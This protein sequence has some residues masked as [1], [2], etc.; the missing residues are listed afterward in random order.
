MRISWGSATLSPASWSPQG[1]RSSIWRRVGGAWISRGNRTGPPVTRADLAAE[2]LLQAGLPRVA[3][4]VP[5]V[6]EETEPP[7]E[8]VRE[9][10]LVD[11][12]DGTKEFLAGRGEFT[13]QAALLHEGRATLGAVHAPARGATCVGI[14]GLGAWVSQQGSGWRALQ[15]G[16]PVAGAPLRVVAS[17]SHLDAGIA[18]FLRRLRESGARVEMRQLGS[19]WKLCL[20]ALG[21]AELYPRFAPTWAW[22]VAAGHAVLAGA[23]GHVT[24]LAGEELR[25]PPRRSRN[26]P[27]VASAL[28]ARA[29]Q[30]YVPAPDRFLP[31]HVDPHDPSPF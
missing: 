13:V 18:D 23:G 27:F 1:G 15:V 25:Y 31:A 30:P 5:V 14:P 24:T 9:Y 11:P 16:A 7:C 10:W 8:I 29:W 3:P 4:G 17:R 6:S 2:R 19:A 12:L 22:D 21:E 28:P 26:P 20:L